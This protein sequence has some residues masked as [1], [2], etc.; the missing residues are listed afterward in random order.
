MRVQ[1]ETHCGSISV[2]LG[3]IDFMFATGLQVDQ[4]GRAVQNAGLEHAKSSRLVDSVEEAKQSTITAGNFIKSLGVVLSKIEPIMKVIDDV[5]R[6]SRSSCIHSLAIDWPTRFIPS[7][8]KSTRLNSSH[9]GE[10]R[11]PS[12]A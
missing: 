6:V 4:T 3:H 1:P 7:D 12:S 9:S 5:S 2:K 10:S 11:M 8:R